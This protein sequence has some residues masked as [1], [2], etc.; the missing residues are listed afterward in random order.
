MAT[1]TVSD[2]MEGHLTPN[3]EGFPACNLA[4]IVVSKK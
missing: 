3:I 2:F 4:E 1:A